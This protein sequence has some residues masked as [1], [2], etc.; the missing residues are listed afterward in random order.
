[1]PLRVDRAPRTHASSVVR[2]SASHMRRMRTRIPEHEYLVRLGASIRVLRDTLPRFMD[3]ALVE[4]QG[5]ERPSGTAGAYLPR[6]LPGAS[7][8]PLHAQPTHL[9]HPRIHFRFC[10]PLPHLPSLPPL[11]LPADASDA[12]SA[13]A[14]A[15]RAAVTPS[16]VPSAAPSFS[17]HGR[18]VY[19]LSARML[20]WLLHALFAQP[21][22]VLESLVLLPKREGPS[23][24]SA[25]PR[26]S[27][28]CDE[29]IARLRF[30]G[31]LRLF[32]TPHDYTL[33]FRYR[34]DR[35]TGTICEHIV[36]KME[37]VPG[38]RVW[39]GLANARWR[40]RPA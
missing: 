21:N 32:G 6:S 25:P 17:L 2:F 29:L 27:M 23:T 31:T 11:G 8:T 30:N 4:R 26:G 3:V 22:V 13:G 5:H 24:P 39:Q 1:M 14:G 15:G 40:L 37:P 28:P 7:L 20:R 18:G 9:Y 33:M 36:D 10:V 38:S 19:L 35:A 34:F 16:N 12:G